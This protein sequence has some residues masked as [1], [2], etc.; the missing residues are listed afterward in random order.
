MYSMIWE[1]SLIGRIHDL[2]SCDIGSIP[3][4]SILGKITQLVEWWNHNP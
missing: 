4:I 3:I 1:Y 2:H